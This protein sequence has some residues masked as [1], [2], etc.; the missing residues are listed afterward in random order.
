MSNLTAADI[1]LE[2]GRGYLYRGKYPQVVV[3]TRSLTD[4]DKLKQ[5]FGGHS[6]EHKRG[7]VWIISHRDE[8]RSMLEALEPRKSNHEFED[9]IGDALCGQKSVHD[10]A[11]KNP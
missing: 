9:V 1:V 8:L 7:H 11:R 4:L 10:A 6:H 5:A 3:F 2:R